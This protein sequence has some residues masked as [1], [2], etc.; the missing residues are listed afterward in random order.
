MTPQV[1]PVGYLSHLWCNRQ[2]IQKNKERNCF[3]R[4]MPL[5]VCQCEVS[6]SLV[7]GAPAKSTAVRRFPRVAADRG[8][9]GEREGEE[10][11]KLC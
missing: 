7:R 11:A 1:S 9:R 10:P 8:D 3:S 6:S 4:V 5:E 2:A